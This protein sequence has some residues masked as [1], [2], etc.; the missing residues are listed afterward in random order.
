MSRVSRAPS[1][2]KL[3]L[4]FGLVPRSVAGWGWMKP[5]SRAKII[6]VLLETLMA[7]LH[8]LNHRLLQAVVWFS[9]ENSVM[10]REFQRCCEAKWL[11]P[12]SVRGTET[13]ER[14]SYCAVKLLLDMWGV[15]TLFK[16]P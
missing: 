11:L 14:E 10:S 12:G 2:N 5:R 16:N 6:V 1:D 4:P 3:C 7:I 15:P 13:G 8:S 9:V